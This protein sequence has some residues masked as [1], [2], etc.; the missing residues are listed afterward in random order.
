MKVSVCCEFTYDYEV[1]VPDNEEDVLSYCDGEDPIFSDLC[2]IASAHHV[3]FDAEID[4]IVNVET[5]E[6]IDT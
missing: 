4:S 1:D 5:G 6:E 3:N 2:K